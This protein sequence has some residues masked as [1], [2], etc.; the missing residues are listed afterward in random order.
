MNVDNM[1]SVVKSA[2]DDLGILDADDKE[3]LH[4]AEQQAKD[5]MASYLQ[6]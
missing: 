4:V 3:L 5:D 2:I 1:Q 6:Q